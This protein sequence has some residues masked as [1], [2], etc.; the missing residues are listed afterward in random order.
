M[1]FMATGVANGSDWAHNAIDLTHQYGDGSGVNVG[2]M[3]GTTRCSH[4]ELVGR[5]KNYFPSDFMGT[6]YSDHGTH[7]ATIIG[8]VDKAPAWMD[9]GLSLIHI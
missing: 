6:Y 7:V 8:G 5:C 2:I 9:H 4:Q 3:D 1:L